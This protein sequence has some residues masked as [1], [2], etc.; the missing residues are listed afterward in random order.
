MP[1]DGNPTRPYAPAPQ[2]LP[3]APQIER[4]H[5]SEPTLGA[6]EVTIVPSPEAVLSLPPAGYKLGRL[7]GR[8]GMGEV[9][10]A[11]DERI[12]RGV[13]IKRMRNPK[14][15]SEALARF[16][17]EARIQARLDHPAIVPVHD[18]GVDETGRPYFTM[19]RCAGITLQRLIADGGAFHRLLRAFVDVCLA[20]DFAHSRGVVHRDLKPANIMLGDY[21]EVYVLDWGVARVLSEQPDSSEPSMQRHDE[22]PDPDD[23]TKSGALLGT[24]G[25]IPPEQIE[26]AMAAPP[27]DVYALGCILFEILAC[28]PLHPRGQPAIGRTLSAPQDSPARRRPDRN[29]PPELD[30]ACFAALADAPKQRPTARELADRV[31]AYLDGDRDIERRRTLAAQQVD[32]ARSALASDDP[33]NRVIALR[34]AGR[35]VALDPESLPAAQLV[36]SLLLEPPKDDRRNRWPRE[37]T[38]SF[39]EHERRINRDRSRKAIY[40]YLAIIAIFPIVLFLDVKNW[41]ALAAFYGCVG[42]G[43]MASMNHLRTGVPSMPVVLVVNLALAVLFSRVAGPFVLTPLVICA[44]LAGITSI[45][46]LGEHKWVAVG[47]A[48]CASMLPVVLE[49]IDVLPNTW[50][51]SNG[52]MMIQSDVFTTSGLREEVLLTFVNTL[53]T[54]TVAMLALAI[55][56]RRRV[57]QNT[58]FVHAWHLRQLVP[59]TQPLPTR[60]S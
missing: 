23:S 15:N 4:E 40:A 26:G 20:I 45:A 55:S 3:T 37:L 41:P 8:G 48:V 47:W 16:L 25:Y 51:I 11:H 10:A 36:S 22:T 34:K 43:I 14:P 13:A 30:A 29:L 21:G 54:V 52:A 5:A 49:W 12:G 32:E 56:Y 18:L 1:D 39:E 53:F 7:I 9:I 33:E 24:P 58:L 6:T 46:W 17:R 28:E 38:A 31:Q 42:L 2:D 35:A 44:S 50:G 19:K 60:S 59:N 27:A 57:S